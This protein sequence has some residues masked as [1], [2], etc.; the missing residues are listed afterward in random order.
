MESRR[1]THKDG[2]PFWPQV[3]TK[4]AK[5]NRR[6][7]MYKDERRKI[8]MSNFSS[9]IKLTTRN[10]YLYVV[11]VSCSYCCCVELC[12]AKNRNYFN[13]IGPLQNANELKLIVGK[14]AGDDCKENV[15][16]EWWFFTP[17]FR[18]VCGHIYFRLHC[19]YMVYVR[20]IHMDVIFCVFFLCN[21]S[22]NYYVCGAEKLVWLVFQQQYM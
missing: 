2:W 9:I 8:G 18:F 7:S 15:M 22:L 5:N 14:W 12:P 6:R 13:F 1:G 21:V 20:T 4:A 17:T 10:I 19:I 11:F 3:M 16:S